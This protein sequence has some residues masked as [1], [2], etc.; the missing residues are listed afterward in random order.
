MNSYKAVGGLQWFAY[1][2]LTTVPLVGTRIGDC[3]GACDP[4]LERPRF[5]P[6]L[7]VQACLGD[8]FGIRS[9]SRIL[10]ECHAHTATQGIA[11]D[12]HIFQCVRRGNGLVGECLR[13]HG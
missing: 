5:V 10:A 11:C 12:E 3:I 6:S 4:A 7:K 2:I 1:L 13:R 8:V 9:E